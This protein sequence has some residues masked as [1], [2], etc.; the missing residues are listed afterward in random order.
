MDEEA[1]ELRHHAEH[2]RQLAQGP[3]N[4]RIR[5]TLLVMAGEFDWQAKDVEAAEKRA[6]D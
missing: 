6:H 4:E 1:R 2:C 5:T 3:C